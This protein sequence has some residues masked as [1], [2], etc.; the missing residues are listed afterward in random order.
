MNEIKKE[1]DKLGYIIDDVIEDEE[2]ISYIYARYGLM[3]Y[4]FICPHGGNNYKYLIRKNLTEYLD[5]WSVC[6]YQEAY[7]TSIELINAI[8]YTSDLEDYIKADIAEQK[9]REWD[10]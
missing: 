6:D 9:E 7:D 1:L 5:R 3:S 10:E 8:D 4:F 2:G